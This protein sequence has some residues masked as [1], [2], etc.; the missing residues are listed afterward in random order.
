MI[1][2]IGIYNFLSDGFKNHEKQLDFF[3]KKNYLQF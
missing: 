2:M 3:I 1:V